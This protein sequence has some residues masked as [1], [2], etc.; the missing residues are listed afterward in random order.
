MTTAVARNQIADPTTAI[1]KSRT[2]RFTPPR[3]SEGIDGG[4]YHTDTKL[5]ALST[6]TMLQSTPLQ[7]ANVRTITDRFGK[8][9]KDR[10][11]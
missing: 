6:D 9:F 11:L 5:T 10:Q 2:R 4:G 7:Y 3:G 1:L 8:D